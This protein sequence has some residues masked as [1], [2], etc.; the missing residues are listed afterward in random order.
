MRSPFREEEEALTE[1]LALSMRGPKRN[2]LFAVWLF[3][4]LSNEMFPGLTVTER[5][6]RRRLQSFERRLS[7]LSLPPSLRR[8]I[9]EAS[10]TLRQPSSATAAQALQQLQK[11]VRESLG[12]RAGD[13][14]AAAARRA[15]RLADSET[16]APA[17][18]L[19]T[20]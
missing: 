4:R 13:C 3:L 19:R 7:S 17:G 2:G 5:N 1:A 9:V 18:R 10:R 14:L 6:H 20:P 16:A 11:P 12:H 15:T 8:A